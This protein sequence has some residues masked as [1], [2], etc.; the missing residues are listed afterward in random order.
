MTARHAAI[1]GV[2]LTDAT[3]PGRQ[4]RSRIELAQ[5]AAWAA[6]EHAGAAPG[7]LDGIVVGN[8]D[9]FEGTSLGGKH[10]TRLLGLGA[11]VP[12]TI[13]NT[14]GTTGG[15]LVHV[16]ARMVRSG[17][18]ERVLCLGPAT[19]D[20]ARDL[21]FVINTNSPMIVE[22]PLGMGAVHMGAFFPSAYQER[23]GVSA[24]ELAHAAVADHANAGHNPRAHLRMPLEL[25]DVTGSRELSSPLTLSMV[26][27]VS[28]GACALVVGSAEAGAADRPAAKIRAI[29]SSSDPYLGGGRG[30]FAG[31]ENL[32]ILAR[33]VYRLAGIAD[34]RAEIDVAEVF[35]PYSP[36]QPMQLEAL[37]FC[38][39]GEGAELIR[40]GATEAGGD[41][42]TNLSGGPK[43]TNPGVAGELAP[44]AYVALQLMG[45]APGLQVA[46]ARVGLAHGTGGTFF[47]FNNLAILERT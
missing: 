30:D 32:A 2:G 25:D 28:S 16:A 8:I 42:P 22:Q 23:F 11:E 20:G 37:G 14:G 10:L 18:H 5:E 15:N 6:L 9:N 1:A 12:L 47:Q 36:M 38:P 7:E 39:S 33:R 35:A 21:Q 29:G 17:D 31:F 41:I 3:S 19:F 40:S 27:P 4:H 43:C 26:C 24:G 13:V 34:P 46:G 45:E 44:Y